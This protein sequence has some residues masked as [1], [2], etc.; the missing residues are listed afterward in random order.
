MPCVTSLHIHIRFTVSALHSA[1]NSELLPQL[2]GHKE[3]PIRHF[4]FFLSLFEFACSSSFA[5]SWSI[6]VRAEW[7]GT[8]PKPS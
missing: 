3:V 8:E 1:G 4:P 6:H 5:F 7:E 2:R